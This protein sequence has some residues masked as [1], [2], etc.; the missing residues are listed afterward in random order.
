MK[1]IFYKLFKPN[2]KIK[3][4]MKFNYLS[5]IVLLILISPIIISSQNLNS[6]MRMV[7]IEEKIYTAKKGDVVRMEPGTYYGTLLLENLQ[8]LT[9]DFTG[10]KL[11]T[12]EDVTIFTLKNCSNIK[13]IGLTLRHDLM[14]CFTNCFD[15]NTCKNI[16]FTN[17]DI[18]G[19]GY[20]GI[21][22]NKSTGIK[23][24]NCKIH[25]C[26]V[27]IFLWEHNEI[28]NDI[29]ATTSDVTVKDC[30]FD[31]NEIGNICFDP[32]YADLTDFK[33]VMNGKKFY[34]N[35]HNFKEKYAL[36]IYYII[37]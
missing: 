13:I 4:Y 33:V 21:C 23:V 6:K 32:N 24:K 9:L 12:E 11:I 28:Y 25:Q 5:S 19:S 1:N 3:S 14:G 7:D 17:C 22:V 18:N 34:V 2:F 15:V 29:P 8:N 26:V 37:N 35:T 10:V 36:N 16:R 20:I 31:S 30:I 27:G